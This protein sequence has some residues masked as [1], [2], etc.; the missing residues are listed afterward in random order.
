MTLKGFS[1]VA[2]PNDGLAELEKLVRCD[3]KPSAAPS[4]STSLDDAA[5]KLGLRDP[6]EE[7]LEVQEDPALRLGRG[8]PKFVLIEVRESGVS[9]MSFRSVTSVKSVTLPNESV[10]QLCTE[11]PLD[12]TFADIGRGDPVRECGW[13]SERAD[14]GRMGCASGA[15]KELPPND[16]TCD[17]D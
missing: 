15:P 4:L 10:A 12:D 11:E 7:K 1:A 2:A 8:E 16:W 14:G 6:D 9:L 3:P 5:L 13:D 17:G